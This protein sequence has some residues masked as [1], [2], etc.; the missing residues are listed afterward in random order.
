MKI[1]HLHEEVLKLGAEKASDE[2]VNGVIN[3]LDAVQ[4]TVIRIESKLDQHISDST[5]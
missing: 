5:K 2:K 1:E 4:G 3:T